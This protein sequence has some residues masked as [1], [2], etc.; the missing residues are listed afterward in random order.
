VVRVAVKAHGLSSFS[1]LRFLVRAGFPLLFGREVNEDLIVG[2]VVVLVGDHIPV[3][4][5][6]GHLVGE[7]PV[8]EPPSPQNVEDLLSSLFEELSKAATPSQDSDMISILERGLILR[9]PS[10]PAA[11]AQPLVPLRAAEEISS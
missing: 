8:D 3:E 5:D 9:A 6:P 10:T 4:D 7:S 11:E 1:F 2:E